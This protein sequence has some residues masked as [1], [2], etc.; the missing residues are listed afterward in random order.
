MTRYGFLTDAFQNHVDGTPSGNAGLDDLK[1]SFTYDEFG[2]QT[3]ET[4]NAGLTGTGAVAA[5]TAT[6][7]DLLGNT[8][9]TT[10]YSTFNGT[11]FGGER[12]TRQHF[13]VVSGAS[14]PKASAQR[15]PDNASGTGTLV[16]TAAPA[17]LC[18][19]G[20]G[21]RCNGV[22]ALDQNGQADC[23][24]R[25]VRKGHP[26]PARHRGQDRLLDRELPGR[27]VRREC[28]RYRR[29]H[30]DATRPVR[31]CSHRHRRPQPESHDQVRWRLA[32][33]PA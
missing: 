16:P 3:S 29:G 27:D 30:D 33:P 24:H 10:V 19:D 31:P 22:T 13:E 1:T 14:R 17:P 7:H 18:P 9:S 28:A 23:H 21:L 32:A 2:T 4:Q 6:T 8:V 26:N 20:S 12:V 11:A 25:R 15:G 5:R